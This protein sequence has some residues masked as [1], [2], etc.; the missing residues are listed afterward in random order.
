[1]PLLERIKEVFKTYGMTATAI[2]LAA[3]I[4]IGVVHVVVA[5]TKALNATGKALGNG[6]KKH[7][8]NSFNAARTPW[9]YC[10]LSVAGHVV[11]FLLS[12]M[13]IL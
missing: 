1:M 8:K 2:F 6:V 4:T 3:G 5:I 13:Y 10:E 11:G 7:G 12:K 9:Q